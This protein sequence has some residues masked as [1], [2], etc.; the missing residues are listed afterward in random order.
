M[1][2]TM[3]PPERADAARVAEV[4]VAEGVSRVLLFG[5][6]GDVIDRLTGRDLET[7]EPL[8]PGDAT[9]LPR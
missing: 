9:T 8:D 6:V 1:P 2:R 7:G 5:S 3:K 4:W